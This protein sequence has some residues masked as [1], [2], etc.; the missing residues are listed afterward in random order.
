MHLSHLFEDLA[1]WYEQSFP[2]YEQRANA[3]LYPGQS[4]TPAP[5][6]LALQPPGQTE[7]Q[8]A[9]GVQKY[10]SYGHTGSLSVVDSTASQITSHYGEV[11]PAGTTIPVR[12]DFNTLDNPFYYTSDPDGDLYTN[13]PAAGLHFLIFQPTTAHL[14]SRP[15]LD[16]RPLP[17][18]D[19]PCRPALPPRRHQLGPAYDPPA[20]LSGSTTSPSL[21]PARR[22]PCLT[23]P[24][25]AAAQCDRKG[26]AEKAAGPSPALPRSPGVVGS[27]DRVETP[28]ET[29]REF[30]NKNLVTHTLRPSKGEYPYAIEPAARDRRHRGT[31]LVRAGLYCYRCARRRKQWRARWEDFIRRYAELYRELD[32]IWECG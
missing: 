19:T 5:G 10:H 28:A 25:P 13:E 27:T 22:V 21:L 26:R 30:A 4:P 20:E 23:P 7:A 16:G 3:M 8:V 6:T 1:T 11:Y 2:Q 17:R 12:G 14:Q 31:R 32:R 18:C 24:A 29:S 15:A 9:H